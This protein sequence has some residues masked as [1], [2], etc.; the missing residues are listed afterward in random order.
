MKMTQTKRKSTE[1]KYI[2]VEDLI[3]RLGL[4]DID[5]YSW[6]YRDKPKIRKDHRGRTSVPIEFIERYST[7]DEYVD[8]FRR[9]VV[10][11]RESRGAD[12]SQRVLRL[13]NE[14]VKLLDSY[15]ICI[16]DL[17][18][19]HHKYLD[20]ANRA[21]YET[22]VMASYLLLSRVISTLK[23]TCLCLRNNYW[24]SG[25]LL[26]EIDECLDVAKFFVLTKDTLRGKEALRQWFR[27]NHAPR[28]EDCRK[29]IAIQMA[30]FDTGNSEEHHREL[31]NELY[32]KKSKFT[33]PTYATI[34]EVT[35]YKVEGVTLVEE[36]DYG[37]CSYEQ[38]LHELTHFSRSSIWS[39][40]QTFLL[41]FIHE[42]PLL[43]EDVEY[44]RNYDKK[45]QEWDS[46]A[47]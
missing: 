47:W 7:C 2:A 24:N 32:Q 34:R 28:H 6:L 31:L 23:M 37:P 5:V 4:L 18:T 33:H 1:A 27:E 20:S 19:L 13:R 42:L 14:R 26:R 44:L 15:D 43:K 39:S 22:S 29:E 36:I 8:A 40:F 17:E 9:A 3:G 12:T 35:K 30:S 25:S 38:K 16:R 41:C 21:G 11:E 46:V 45:F 10:A